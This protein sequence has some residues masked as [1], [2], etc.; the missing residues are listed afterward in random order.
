MNG[1]MNEELHENKNPII[2]SNLENRKSIVKG[3]NGII[4]FPMSS[5]ILSW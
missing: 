4:A 3:M 5:D 2:V 1:R